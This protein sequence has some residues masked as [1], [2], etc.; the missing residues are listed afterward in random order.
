MVSLDD[1]TLPR[2]Q[3]LNS[4]KELL[5]WQPGKDEYNIAQTP[6]HL[7]PN[8][9][10]SPS[11]WFPGRSTPS[12]DVFEQFPATACGIANDIKPAGQPTRAAADTSKDRKDCRVI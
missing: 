7:R 1:P 6:L 5:A 8:D 11:P 2:S 4:F 9:S 3:P 12:S 10:A